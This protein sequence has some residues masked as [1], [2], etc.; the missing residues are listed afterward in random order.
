MFK[1]IQW[2]EHILNGKIYVETEKQ[3]QIN[4]DINFK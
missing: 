4:N 1:H 3:K 2:F